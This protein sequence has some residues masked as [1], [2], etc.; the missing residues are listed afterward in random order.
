[1]LTLFFIELKERKHMP[2]K[3]TSTARS[4]KPAVVETVINVD[5]AKSTPAIIV[6]TAKDI[7]E[8]IVVE[9]IAPTVFVAKTY[10]ANDRITCIS[11]TAGELIYY[12]TKTLER[13]EWSNYG[14]ETDVLYEDLLSMKSSKHSFMFSPNFIIK[15][16]E[17]L[18][19]SPWSK[20]KELSEQIEIVDNAEDYLNQSPEDLRK[21]LIQAPEGIK[22]TIKVMAS[23]MISAGSLYDVR[24]IKILDEVLGT[25][26]VAFVL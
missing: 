19:T 3:S 17:L 9:T 18:S 25:D 12:S 26:F 16:E 22:Q 15:D 23:Q 1:M 2:P 11:V 14:D 5:V 20:I 7:S 8:T 6:D 13:Y 24:K 10:V 21:L 4:I